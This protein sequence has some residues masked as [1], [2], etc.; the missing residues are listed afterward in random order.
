MMSWQNIQMPKFVR[1][2]DDARE[3]T[4]VLDDC[5]TVHLVAKVPKS[6]KSDKIC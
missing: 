4:S 5:H 2:D 1:S 3:A 6:M